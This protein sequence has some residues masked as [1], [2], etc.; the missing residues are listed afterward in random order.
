MITSTCSRQNLLQSYH[1][2]IS[3]CPLRI[4]YTRQAS[5]EHRDCKSINPVIHRRTQGNVA[6]TKILL[7]QEKDDMDCLNVKGNFKEVDLLENLLED[8]NTQQTSHQVA[9]IFQLL[10]TLGNNILYNFYKKDQT[11]FSLSYPKKFIC[12]T[13][14]GTF[15]YIF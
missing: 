11:S 6:Q 1:N 7:E 8:P 3:F 9:I 2:Q 10:K 14:K 4:V 12:S 5:D 15:T 13:S